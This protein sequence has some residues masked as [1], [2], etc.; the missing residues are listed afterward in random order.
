MVQFLGF[1]KGTEYEGIHMAINKLGLLSL[2]H[3]HH[4]GAISM[5]SLRMM[6]YACARSGEILGTYR[7]ITKSYYAIAV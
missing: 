7:T 5:L 6:R 2:Q 3:T 4:V 1:P